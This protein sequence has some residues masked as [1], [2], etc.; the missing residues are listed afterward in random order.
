MFGSVSIDFLINTKLL[1]M[2]IFNYIGIF[3]MDYT[4][5]QNWLIWWIL[6]A[7]QILLCFYFL[8]KVFIINILNRNFSFYFIKIDYCYYYNFC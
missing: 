8:K 2:F 3:L 1:L 6:L 5:I 7:L 4:N